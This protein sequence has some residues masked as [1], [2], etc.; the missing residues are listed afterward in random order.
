[1]YSLFQVGEK[2]VTSDYFLASF[3]PTWTFDCGIIGW[4]GEGGLK[5]WEAPE[6]DAAAALIEAAVCWPMASATFAALACVSQ[7]NLLFILKYP[8]NK[9]QINRGILLLLLL[10]YSHIWVSW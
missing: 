2:M 10:N 6:G 7:C 9:F 1:M 8:K 5:V 4:L 3:F